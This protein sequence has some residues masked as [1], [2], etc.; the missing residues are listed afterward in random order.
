M[1]DNRSQE[2]PTTDETAEVL[3][4]EKPAPEPMTPARV[5]EWN[6]YYDLY[7]ALFVVLL[8]FL[9]SANKI[10]G[11]NSGIFSQLQAG[12]QIVESRAPVVTDTTSIAGEGRRWVN[13]PWLFELSHYGLY[14]AGAA[15]MLPPEP[16]IPDG[17][18]PEVVAKI[19]REA[20]IA[21]ALA[22]PKAEQFGVG[23]MIAFDALVRALAAFVLLGLRRKGPGLWWTA[24]CVTIALGV[25]LVPATIEV[26]T[27]V[28]GGGP[29]DRTLQPSVVVQ[30]GGIA[31]VASVVNPETWGLLFGA[32]E[33]LLIHQAVN[34]GK[35]GRLFGL[36]PLFLLWANI[37]DSFAIGLVVLAT[38][39]IGLFFDAGRNPSSPSGRSG[40]IALGLCFAACFANPSHVFGVLG[41]FGTMLRIFYLSIGP[42]SMEPISLFGKKFSEGNP[43][44]IAQ[45]LRTYYAILVGMGLASFL[46]N[47]R[48]FA[49][50]RFLTFVVL[51]ILWVLAFNDFTWMFAIVLVSTLGLNGQEWY[52]GVFGVEGRMGAGWTAWSTGG[53]LVTIALVF[54]AIATTV[55][56]WGGH[57]GDLQFGFGFNPDDFPFEA[58]AELKNA[59]IEG[60]ILNTTIAQGD[61]IAWKALSKHKAYVDSRAHLYPQSVFDDLK[62]LRLDLKNDDIE[63]WQPIL[64]RYKISVV[65]IQL[66]GDQRETAPLTYAKLMR[67]PN[68]IPFYD[69]GSVVMFGRADAQ[70]LPK[71]LAY[72]KDNRLD[73]DLRA[74]KKSKIVPNWERTPI[75]TGLLDRIFQNRLLNRTQPHVDAAVRWMNPADAPIGKPFLPTPAN[76]LMAIR[77]ARIA[78]T[79]KPD[80]TMAFQRLTEA[81]QL[82]LAEES[83]LIAGIPLTPENTARIVQSAPQTRLLSNRARQLLTVLNF[84]I[85]TNP[86]PKTRDEFAATASLNYKLA[87]FYL[88]V[89]ARDLARERML[90][91]AEDAPRSGM[92]D[93]FLKELTKGIGEL[94][95]Q[96]RKLETELDQATIT[97]RLGPMEKASLARS[98]GFPSL[99][100]RIL[101]EAND[102]GAAVPGVLPTLVDLYCEV[103]LPDKA[104]DAI[105]DLETNS[106]KISTGTGTAAFR[107]GLV[108]YLLGSYG[109]TC[110]LWRDNSIFQITSERGLQAP[111]AGVMLLEGDPIASTRMFL[112]LPE[113]LN[114]QAQWEFDLGMAALEGGFPPEYV[115]E[116][117]EEA[118]KLEPDLTVRPVIAYY[119]EKLGK[120]VPPPRSASPK[121]AEPAK[122]VTEPTPVVEPA[123][124]VE[125]PLNPFEP[126]KPAETPK[127]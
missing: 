121:K 104:F 35:T 8:V 37:D 51:S 34:L 15:V 88:Q 46:L 60:N 50:G 48:K 112:E 24:I 2:T 16:K 41:G 87:Q 117:L 76:C 44:E 61:A 31:A 43:P 90:L 114:T 3:A 25:T 78:L 70:A 58:A 21:R 125:L 53:R 105:L 99:A 74:Y 86:P 116:H 107:Q 22:E 29:P 95:E 81:Y 69:D 42:P 6:A 94:N 11:L 62:K 5:F 109:Y 64:D 1:T 30:M 97:Y 115:A 13:T 120:P 54:L 57:V 38:N 122:A 108:Y 19:Q 77:E 7:V 82:L 18:T 80:D 96:L 127:P 14:S 23:T 66:I 17:A 36:I 72:F 26:F 92:R 47:R 49:V 73:A 4:A 85:S 124:P 32:I 68:W 79:I 102:T 65:M 20:A 39:V 71:D 12:R 101:E 75:A 123:K 106:N 113:K 56:G 52:Q 98:R 10:Q 83:A 126:N 110:S 28:A 9:G 89:G 100:I 67:S 59:P 93:D 27:P 118:L 103:G 91:V 45:S 111:A 63:K 33:L 119:L 55:T 84:R 40:L